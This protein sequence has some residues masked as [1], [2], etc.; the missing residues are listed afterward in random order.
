MA[1]IMGV[2]IPA[3]VA[4]TCLATVCTITQVLAS[5]VITSRFIFALARDNGIPFSK[6]LVKTSKHKEPWVAMTCLLASLYVSCVGWFVNR[7]NYYG[8]LQAFNFYFICIPYVSL[9]NQPIVDHQALP[10][11]LYVTSHI[12]LRYVGRAEFSLGRFSRPIAWVVIAWLTLT[13]IQG[14]MPL[15]MFNGAGMY[16]QSEWGQV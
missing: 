6:L 14:S 9:L 8:L 7:D 16:T 10:L 11:L 5:T 4:I 1:I 13:T 3:I 12:D 15:T 2:G